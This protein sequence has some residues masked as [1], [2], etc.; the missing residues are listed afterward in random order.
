M[1]GIQQKGFT[2]I[3]LLVVIA[4]IGMLSAVLLVALS[5]ARGKGRTAGALQQMK[6]VQ[7]YY[8]R[9]VNEKA[10]A[11]TA[12]VAA[13]FCLP[14]QATG[15][16]GGAAGDTRSGGAALM[17]IGYPDTYPSLPSGWIY[18]NSGAAETQASGGCGNETSNLTRIANGPFT[19]RAEGESGGS[20]ITCG[21]T[22]CA[23]T[24]EATPD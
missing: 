24:T 9:C 10:A 12:L 4:I 1:K 19:I 5:V 2:L 6:V 18:C 15:G 22:Q 21:E 20:I 3:E 17:C 14:G 11:G 16:C 7:N 13:Q 8:N 23:V